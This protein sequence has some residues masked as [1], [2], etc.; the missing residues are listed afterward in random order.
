MNRSNFLFLFLFLLLSAGTIQAQVDPKI[1][2]LPHNIKEQLILRATEYRTKG[3]FSSAIIQLDSIL[4][5][6]PMDAPILLFKG[7]LLLESKKF[8]EATQIYE[9]LIPLNFE[10]TVTKIN[11]SY[12]LFMNNKAAKA[13]E[14][15]RKAWDSDRQNTN[16][17]INYFNAMLWNRK[18]KDA[19]NFLSE[20]RPILKISEQLL[21]EA[22]LESVAGNFRKDF[23]QNGQLVE[24]YPKKHYDKENKE[25]L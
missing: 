3:D 14:F 10:Q 11:L 6:N 18:T 17:V 25:V 2:P 22:R 5:K 19:N 20:Q 7:D 21:L 8:I 13:L 12:A 4:A 15:A 1:E 9:S 23:K 24:E 16:A